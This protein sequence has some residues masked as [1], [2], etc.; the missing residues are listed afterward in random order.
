MTKIALIGCTSKKQ[1]YSCSAIDM[2]SK[3]SYFKKKIRYCKKINVDKIFILSAKYG[4]LDS[5]TQIE[6][7]NFN[8][9]N[10]DKNY[11]KN[12]NE[13]VLE[14]LKNKTNLEEDEFIIL[15]GNE[16]V[17]DLLEFIPNHYNPVKGLGIG[18]Q[19]FFFKNYKA[20]IDAKN[21][22]NESNMLEIENQPGFYKWWAKREEFDLILEKLEVDYED[23]KEE[24]EKR[25]DYYCIYVGI[26]VNESVRDRLNW[27]VNDIHSLSKVK[28]GTLSTFRQ[29]ISSII[30]IDQ[31]NKECTDE[32]IDKLKIEYFALD[33]PIKSEEAKNS[34][35]NI[36]KKLMENNLYVLNIRDNHHFLAKPIKR[37]LRAIR[38]KGKEN[39]LRAF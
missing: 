20:E 21:L 30:V 23:I 27:H 8:L 2:Y 17:K 39:G 9:K 34:L 33:V 14:N 38:K 24:V 19:S 18:Y 22:R 36:E 28:N 12:W 3:S 15:A 29:S 31:S 7:Y 11:K 35:E 6:P 4:F 10:A 37:K 1:D 5:D 25:N 26:A 13:K 32:F 16:Y